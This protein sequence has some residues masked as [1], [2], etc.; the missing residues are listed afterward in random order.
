L[1]SRPDIAKKPQGR[2]RRAATLEEV[3]ETLAA[4]LAGEGP[5]LIDVTLDPSFSPV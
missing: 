1:N 5:T 3:R 2:V 4:A